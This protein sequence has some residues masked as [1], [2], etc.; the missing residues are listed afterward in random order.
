[1]ATHLVLGPEVENPTE[2]FKPLLFGLVL[3]AKRSRV[4][5]PA[6]VLVQVLRDEVDVLL[7][8]CLTQFEDEF[9]LRGIGTFCVGHWEKVVGSG[10]LWGSKCKIHRILYTH[11]HMSPLG[12]QMTMGN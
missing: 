3:L 7:A 2:F 10:V 12:H 8:E 9:D 11:L 6:I 5:V 1:M 4:S